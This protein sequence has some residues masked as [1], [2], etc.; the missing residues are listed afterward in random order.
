MIHPLGVYVWYEYLGY[1]DMERNQD[2][3]TN[4][5]CDSPTI[6]VG[7]SELSNASTRGSRLGGKAFSVEILVYSGKKT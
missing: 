4:E 3:R 7:M 1:P 6:L 2:I 5:I